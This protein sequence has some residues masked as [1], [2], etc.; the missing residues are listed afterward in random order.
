M[1]VTY[2][3]TKF[4]ERSYQLAQTTFLESCWDTAPGS[5]ALWAQSRR[6]LLRNPLCILDHPSNIWIRPVAGSSSDV[7]LAMKYLVSVHIYYS[8]VKFVPETSSYT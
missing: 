4:Y 5:G 2:S 1:K 8:G 7:M 6:S 3:E